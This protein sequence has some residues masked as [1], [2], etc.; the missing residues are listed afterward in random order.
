MSEY[1]EIQTELSDDG[2]TMSFY[3]NLTLSEGE[4]ET[5]DSPAAME[6]GSPVAQAF[7][8]V[9]GIAQLRLEGSDMHITRAAD[10]PWHSIV[11]DVTAALKDFFL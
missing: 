1:I 7:A 10:A 4:V 3:T 8:V 11:A 6:E 5:Y 2:R 9:D